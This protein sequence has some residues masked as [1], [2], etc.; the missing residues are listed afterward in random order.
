[1]K[2][3]NPADFRI[4]CHP[5]DKSEFRVFHPLT[6]QASAWIRGKE[7]ARE[8]IRLACE[9][10]LL[11]SFMT[12]GDSL[13]Y[14]HN[15]L[16]ELPEEGELVIFMMFKDEECTQPEVS[17]TAL[18]KDGKA[19]LAKFPTCEVEGW[20][21]HGVRWIHFPKEGAK[22][23]AA[24]PESLKRY[25]VIA[26]FWYGYMKWQRD[27]WLGQVGETE[28]EAVSAFNAYSRHF[29]AETRPRLVRVKEVSAD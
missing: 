20:K 7:N 12:Q 6:N 9:G 22:T 21:S 1:M 23:E 17:I 19:V 18:W 14:L 16:L 27:V 15:P 29:S 2:E 11:G 5:H 24:K 3:L 28:D 25:V 8:V 4:I 13:M 26:D 10:K